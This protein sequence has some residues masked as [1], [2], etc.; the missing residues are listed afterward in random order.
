MKRETVRCPRVDCSDGEIRE[1]LACPACRGSG[2]VPADLPVHAETINHLYRKSD[3]ATSRTAAANVRP[4]KSQRH[5]LT[6]LTLGPATADEI[7][8]R[9]ERERLPITPSRVRTAL[10]ELQKSG[11]VALT[12]EIGATRHGRPARVWARVDQ[13]TAVAS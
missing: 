8:L 9:A 11:R 5:V 4:T 7:E 6:L 1:G 3:P 13:Q 10:R 2:R 12:G